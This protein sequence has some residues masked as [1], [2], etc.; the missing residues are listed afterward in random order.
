VKTWLLTIES[1]RTPRT[2]EPDDLRCFIFAPDPA[3]TRS[4]SAERREEGSVTRNLALG[5]GNSF[6]S[7]TLCTTVRG[8]F[9]IAH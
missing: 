5:D 8:D 3:L 4:D 7:L 2:T 1:W 9:E 6:H